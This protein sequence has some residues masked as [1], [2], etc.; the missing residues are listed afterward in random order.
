MSEPRSDGWVARESVLESVEVFRRGAEITRS[1]PLLGGE[2]R[3]VVTELP[4][5]LDDGSVRIEVASGA[6]VVRT[7]RVTIEVVGRAA[8]PLHAEPE[9][10]R[11]L[12]HQLRGMVLELEELRARHARAAG[13][14][15]PERPARD[16]GRPP[17]PAPDRARLE[18]LELR[19]SLQRACRERTQALEIEKREL[20]RRL[21]RLT[22]EH[23]KRSIDTPS[24]HR[25]LKSIAIE[26]E[27]SAPASASLRVVYRVRS[28]RWAPSY[29]LGFDSKARRARLSMR[30]VVAQRT[31]EERS[32]PGPSA[33]ACG[34][35]RGR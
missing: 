15:I 5:E 26:L 11:A 14:S 27:E 20:E 25:V 23:A 6:V 10:L 33:S 1:V 17:P 29:R 2:R 12:R 18:L 30:A 9:E 19:V 4:L 28:A 31:G 34:C 24:R 22:D 35:T 7:F 3:L 13:L 16:H 8:D 32:S 21:R